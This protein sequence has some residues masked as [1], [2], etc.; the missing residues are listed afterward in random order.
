MHGILLQIYDKIN[1][2]N[3]WSLYIKTSIKLKQTID[4]VCVGASTKI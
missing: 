2:I 4:I 3:L 1:K